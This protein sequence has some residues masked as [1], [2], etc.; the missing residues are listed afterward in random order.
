MQNE[1]VS[2]FARLRERKSLTGGDKCDFFESEK[3][4]G[5]RLGRRSEDSDHHILMITISKAQARDGGRINIFVIINTTRYVTK[6][7]ND[8]LQRRIRKQKSEVI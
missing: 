4:V 7:N 8:P 6:D 2:P 3:T 1:V 5:G